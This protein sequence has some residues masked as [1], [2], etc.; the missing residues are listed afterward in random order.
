MK[1]LVGEIIRY[2]FAGMVN[3][4]A[5]YGTFLLLLHGMLW[6]P[7]YAN[8]G[9]YAIGLLVAYTLN[10][11]FVFRYSSHSKGAVLKFIVGFA[12][13]YAL[14]LVVMHLML[15]EVKLRPEFAQLFAMASYTISFYLFNKFFVWAAQSGEFEKTF[16]QGNT[17]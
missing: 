2:L 8:A 13:S 10:L 6:G 4:A 16:K 5:G 11:Q 7:W 17:R 14:N 12:I 15:S 3:T 9:S 1:R